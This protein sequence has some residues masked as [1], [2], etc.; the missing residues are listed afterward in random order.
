ME[1]QGRAALAKAGFLHY[2][3]SAHAQ[4]GRQCRHNLNYW[5]FGDYLGIGAGSHGKITSAEYA[6]IDRYWKQSEPHEYMVKAGLP[7]RISGQR[8]LGNQ[9]LILEFMLNAL[10]LT[11]GFSP[12]LFAAR[13]GL[14][15][16]VLAK[17]LSRA[18]AEGFLSSTSAAIRPTAKGRR[19]LNDLLQCFLPSEES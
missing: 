19:F 9:D 1:Q 3:I 12:P 18:Q 16:E 10:R 13:T 4:R 7:D 5:R 8:Q 15:I 11:N 14:P 2:E 6:R 17:A